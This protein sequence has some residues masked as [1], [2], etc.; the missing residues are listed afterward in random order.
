MQILLPYHQ[1]GLF[2]LFAFSLS[3]KTVTILDPVPLSDMY[4]NSMVDKYSLKLKDI[5]FHLNIALQDAISGWNDDVF[6][7]RRIRT[8]RMTKNHDRLKVYWYYY[9]CSV[10]Y[11]TYIFLTMAMCVSVQQHVWFFGAKVYTIV[12]W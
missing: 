12:E 7:W 11:F 2:I 8:P 6:L 5:S 4:K 10:Q 1:C 3:E 9:R